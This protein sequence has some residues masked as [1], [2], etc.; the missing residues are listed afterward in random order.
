MTDKMTCKIDPLPI[1]DGISLEAWLEK[2]VK[3]DDVLLAHA[4]DGVIWGKI[5]S[6]RLLTSSSFNIATLQEL[7]L[8]NSEREIHV[9]RI[10]DT[11]HARQI[12]DKDDITADD[13]IEES[14]ILWGTK[15]TGQNGIFIT[16]EDGAQGLRHTVP[17]DATGVNDKNS[18]LCLVVRHYFDEDEN[19]GVNYIAYSRLVNLDVKE[20]N[21][22]Q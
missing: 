11:W 2:H 18:R 1:E 16:V 20:F 4:L 15:V 13:Y 6:G 8:F 17:I 19:T 10:G 7:R 5:E 21:D 9:W 3:A 14:H 12:V 22:E